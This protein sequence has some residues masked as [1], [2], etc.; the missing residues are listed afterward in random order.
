MG[1]VS[2]GV[3]GWI[4]V[5]GLNDA[6]LRMAVA[7]NNIANSNTD[8]FMPDRVDSVT[9]SGGGVET[10]MTAG[11]GPAGISGESA[12]SGTDLVLEGVQLILAQRA[13]EANA[14]MLKT[15]ADMGKVN[16]RG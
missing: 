10:M 5:S 11:Y 13:F 4:S 16:I 2:S 1:G 8:G 14:R 9:L 7:A 15:W 3:S 12:P 6:T